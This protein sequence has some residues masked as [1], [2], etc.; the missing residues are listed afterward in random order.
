MGRPPHTSTLGTPPLYLH[1]WDDPAQSTPPHTQDD[2]AEALQAA[3]EALQEAG[4]DLLAP[5]EEDD[6]SGAPLL[7]YELED[8][9]NESWVAQIKASYVPIQISPNLYIGECWTGG[10]GTVQCQC[11]GDGRVGGRTQAVHL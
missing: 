5:D 8:V 3:A 9:A 4:H 2:P 7:R 6:I 11:I 1:T 10:E